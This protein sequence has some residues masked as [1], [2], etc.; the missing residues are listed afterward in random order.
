M[1]RR[2]LLASLG[3]VGASLGLAGCTTH[4]PKP[5][6]PKLETTFESSVF[7]GDGFQPTVLV[8]GSVTNVGPVFVPEA[9]LTCE[10]VDG[11]GNVI[12]DG[13]TTVEK[14]EREESQQF[15]FALA[16]GA[17]EAASFDHAEVAVGYPGDS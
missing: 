13:T 10:L 16:V 1:D 7:V 6:K 3:A 5:G 9:E 8:T 4:L 2:R 11:N 17:T 14:L 12:E 15:A